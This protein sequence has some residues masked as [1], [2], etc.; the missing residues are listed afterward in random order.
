MS[1]I[2]LKRSTLNFKPSM[3]KGD[4]KTKR[5]KISMGSYGKLRPAD[6]KAKTKPE[7][8]AKPAEPKA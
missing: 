5:G 7:A 1:A 4:R 6:K 8:V 3:G 2:A